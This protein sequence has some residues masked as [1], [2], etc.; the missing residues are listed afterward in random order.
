M[1]VAFLSSSSSLDV[2]SSDDV[3]CAQRWLDNLDCVRGAGVRTAAGDWFWLLVPAVG[4]GDCVLPRPTEGVGEFLPKL[5]G[6]SCRTGRGGVPNPDPAGL[7]GR[8]GTFPGGMPSLAWSGIYD[9]VRERAWASRKAA[10]V[11]RWLVSDA[12]LD[13]RGR[14]PAPTMDE[15][16][17]GGSSGEGDS[18]RI[19]RNDLSVNV[20]SSTCGAG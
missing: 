8:S 4:A 18:G 3:F 7:A 19:W 9:E 20:E 14:G 11:I 2:S 17:C 10:T 16:N 13:P 1:I 12:L 6:G 15:G 5:D